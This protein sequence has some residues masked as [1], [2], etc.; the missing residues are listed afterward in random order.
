MMEVQ[1]RPLRWGFSYDKA[2]VPGFR[3][4]Q[5]IEGIVMAG[6]IDT[7]AISQLFMDAR[8]H[9]AWKDE[10]VT[11]AQLR[12]LIDLMKMC[13]TSANCSPARF[14]FLR[15]SEAKQRLAPY[16]MEGNVE[17]TVS[18]PAVAII[19][20]DL[21]FYEHL[22][23]LFPHTDAKSWFEGD[24]QKIQD[25]A[26]RNGTLQGAYFIMAARAIG[27]DTGPMSGFD[28]EGVDQEFFA[29]TKTKSN[30]ICNLG[31]GDPSA[32]F[33]RSPRF[34]FDEIARVL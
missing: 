28:N 1:P 34:E 18:A 32:I 25:T 29:G 27:L 13:P 5:V 21:E 19:G 7:A 26:F 23:K 4:N 8:S 11:E 3:F 15:S 6:T 24:P 12:E 31:I 14:I 22:P 9:N 30:F 17:K 10:D 16:L 20:Y 33:G 2:R